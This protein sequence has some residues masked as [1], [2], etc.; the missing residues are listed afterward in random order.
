M[1]LPQDNTELVLRFYKV[2]DTGNIDQALAM[3]PSNFVAHMAG[4]PEPLDRKG[5]EEFG[6]TFYQRNGV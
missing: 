6:M 1:S 5:F 2:F 3:L 4:M